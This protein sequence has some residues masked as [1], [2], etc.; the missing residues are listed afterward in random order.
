MTDI[1]LKRLT[2]VDPSEIFQTE[3]FENIKYTSFYFIESIDHEGAANFANILEKALG[4]N[5]SNNLDSNVKYKILKFWVLRLKLFGFECLDTRERINLFKTNIV[6]ILSNDLDFKEAVFRYIDVFETPSLVIEITKGYINALASSQII[7]GEGVAKFQKDDFQPTVS[8]WLKQYQYSINQKATNLKPSAFEVIN[9]LNKDT[10]V[11]YLSHS[12]RKILNSL[13]E[14]YNWLISPLVYV[15]SKSSIQESQYI[16][17]Q[18]FEIPKEVFQS[19]Q[20][21]Q[22][23]VPLVE[24]VIPKPATA[25]PLME[26]RDIQTVSAPV[27]QKPKEVFKIESPPPPVMPAKPAVRPVNEASKY[28]MMSGD[29]GLPGLKIWNNNPPTEYKKPAV[30][31]DKKLEDLKKKL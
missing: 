2:S 3:I 25:K 10:N 28:K 15:D 18:K 12:E 20:S 23:H 21:V 1:N 29:T 4:Q 17:R 19:V 9:F 8:N 5:A 24:P 16:S 31:I 14:L 30:D 22:T 7:L 11:K 13:L 26:V 27:F 6:D